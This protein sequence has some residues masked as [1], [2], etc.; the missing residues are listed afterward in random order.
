MKS[1]VLVAFG[2]AAAGLAGCSSTPSSDPQKV[3]YEMQ[4]KQQE[5]QVQAAK[6]VVEQTPPWYATPP[7]DTGYMYGV[8]T[9]SSADLQFAI[10]KAALNAKR[11]LADQVRGKLSA[12]VKDYLEESGGSVQPISAVRGERTMHDVVTDVDLQGYEVSQRKVVASG[13][14][15]R[16]F[17]L[18]RYPVTAVAR[19]VAAEVK[20][21]DAGGTKLRAAK[22]FDDLEK[23]I[24]DA[25]THE[26]A[27][28]AVG[29]QQAAPQPP[30][31]I[32]APRAPVQESSEPEN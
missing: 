12:D 16:A 18:I 1:P 28:V 11:A 19:Q 20:Q 24:N 23:E 22:A 2:L 4:Q 6:D 17:V 15:Y 30:M 25:Q 27:P 10:D 32:A 5:A 31:P 14:G 8:G 7:S 21:D 3:A 29:D 13:T 9:A 26:H